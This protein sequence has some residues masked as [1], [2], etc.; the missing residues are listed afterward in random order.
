MLLTFIIL[1]MDPSILPEIRVFSPFNPNDLNSVVDEIQM[2]LEQAEAGDDGSRPEQ[3]VNGSVSSASSVPWQRTFDM[4]VVNLSNFP[5]NSSAYKLNYRTHNSLMTRAKSSVISS[6]IKS[7]NS[8][9]AVLQKSINNDIDSV[10]QTYLEKFFKPAI[11]NLKKNTGDDNIISDHQLQGVCRTMLEE[12]KKLYFAGVLLGNQ[13]CNSPLKNIIHNPELNSNPEIENSPS[14]LASRK[15]N[16]PDYSENECESDH[17]LSSAIITSGTLPVAKI[18]KKIA[19]KK[20]SPSSTSNH[21][22]NLS[23]VIGK[24][25]TGHRVRQVNPADGIDRSGPRWDPERL[26]TDTKFVLGS[27][28]N[29]A[30]GFGALRGRLYTKHPNLFRY[31]GDGEDKV[32]L[33]ERGLM[34]PAGGRAYL[35]VKEDIEELLQ[36]QYQGVPGVCAKA[37]GQG[38]VIPPF[39]IDKM[40]I[41]MADLR[42]ASIHR[43]KSKEES[44]IK[45]LETDSNTAVTDSSLLE[46]PSPQLSDAA[47]NIAS[48]STSYNYMSPCSAITSEPGIDD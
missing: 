47:S 15:R 17:D 6:P 28:A 20:V 41:L 33:S 9:R 7:L 23:R 46:Q 18:R 26:T 8:L 21:S 5:T 32:W 37:M 11:A 24:G 16:R 4:R 19:K 14:Q 44:V 45:S 35:L 22:H 13:R 40:K 31:I 48:P 12:A 2:N 3:G 42:S 10:V 39:M 1:T 29:K 43:K 25:P 27:K 36:S 34:P 30:L 38:F